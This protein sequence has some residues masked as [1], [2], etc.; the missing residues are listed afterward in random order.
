MVQ[1]EA[2]KEETPTELYQRL[3]R[4]TAPLLFF[5][6]GIALLGVTL[7]LKHDELPTVLFRIASLAIFGVY[8]LYFREARL[9]LLGRLQAYVT[10]APERHDVD[11]ILRL[12][13]S[14]KPVLPEDGRT[15]EWCQSALRQLLPR[16]T[17]DE[18]RHL[19]PQSKHSLVLLTRTTLRRDWWEVFFLRPYTEPSNRRIDFGII[20]L[21]S[22]A[23]LRQPGVEREAREILGKVQD[24]RLREAA[25]EYL[26]ALGRP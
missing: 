24:E 26:S 3:R 14:C 13:H 20:L 1:K 6:A 12:H 8:Y 17:S 11:W 5:L 7:V 25:Q 9:T 2:R 10:D 19:S 21:L 4:T 23:T 22:L 18:L 15:Q 16:L